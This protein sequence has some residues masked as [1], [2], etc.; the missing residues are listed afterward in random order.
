[1]RRILFLWLLLIS[2]SCGATGRTE[3]DSIRVEAMLQKGKRL[4][5]DSCL[6]LHYARQFLGVPYVAH[7]LE[8][9]D[10]KESLV[11]NLRQMDCTTLVETVV[12]LTLTTQHGST[13]W[14]DYCSWLTAI[15]YI[16]GHMDGYASRCHY[17]SQWIASAQTMGLVSEISAEGGDDWF[18]FTATQDIQL[19]YMTLHREVYPVISHDEQEAQRVEQYEKQYSG[20]CVRYIPARLIGRSREELSS[21]RDGDIL[22]LVTKKDGLDVSHLGLAVWGGDG[23]LHLL[24]ASSIY[25]RVVLDEVPLYDYLK[26]HPSS[27]GVRV[28]RVNR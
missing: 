8:S 19:H 27:L 25:H 1:M 12:A 2:L 10:G 6:M 4:P 15:R 18:P 16:N 17:F 14:R 21:I 9:L 28:I 23:K 7:T 3:N 22:A 5:E 13:R 11:V 24:N 26:K 20:T